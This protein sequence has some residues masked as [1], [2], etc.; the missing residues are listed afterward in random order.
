MQWNS[1]SPASA[2]RLTPAEMNNPNRAALVKNLKTQA[3]SWHHP[4]IEGQG[5]YQHL[6]IPAN[7]LHSC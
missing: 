2:G 4:L 5:Q 1:F 3:L 6:H 7:H